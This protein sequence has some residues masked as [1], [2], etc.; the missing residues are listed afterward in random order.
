MRGGSR[1]LLRELIMVLL[2]LVFF[3]LFVLGATGSALAQ[4]STDAGEIAGTVRDIA[5]GLIHGAHVTLKGPFTLR[6]RV[7]RTT[8]TDENGQYIFK[9]V[10][11]GTYTV[12]FDLAGYRQTA[13]KVSVGS[14]LVRADAVLR[15]PTIID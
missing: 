15:V 5:G 11:R 1:Q 14:K 2:R 9:N 7:S 12:R 13:S 3:T 8:Q 4:S 6:G 10:R